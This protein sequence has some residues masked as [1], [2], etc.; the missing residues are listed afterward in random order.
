[1]R[2]WAFG[3]HCYRSNPGFPETVFRAKLHKNEKYKEQVEAEAWAA[4]AEKVAQYADRG[5]HVPDEC[6]SMS[7]SAARSILKAYQEATTARAIRHDSLVRAR[8][9]NGSVDRIQAL[10]VPLIEHFE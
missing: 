1:M 6:E 5:V 8:M 7:V 10:G 9:H 2:L 4:D 3:L